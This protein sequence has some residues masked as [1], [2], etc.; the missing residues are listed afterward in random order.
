MSIA[1]KKIHKWPGR[2]WTS[3]RRHSSPGRRGRHHRETP[4]TPRGG[5]RPDETRRGGAA[6]LAS[7]QRA[8]PLRWAEPADPQSSGGHPKA[9]QLRALPESGGHSTA[10][11]PAAQKAW[12]NGASQVCSW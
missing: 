2:A 1:P 3:A 8:R 12:E 4:R 6:V 10:L 11:N 7:S 9:W 5:L